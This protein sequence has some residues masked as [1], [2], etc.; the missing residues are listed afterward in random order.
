MQRRRLAPINIC[1]FCQAYEESVA[2]LLRECSFV[3]QLLRVFQIPSAPSSDSVSWLGWLA[4]FFVSLSE[5]NRRLLAMIY[6]VVWFA[7]NKLVHEG[8]KSSIH[9][10]SCFIKAFVSEQD[11]ICRV[12]DHASPTVVS[13]WETPPPS[14][15]KVN[16]DS[17]FRQQDRAATSGVVARDSEDLVLA[18]CVTPH[19]N[20]SDAFVAEALACK[21]AVQFAKDMGFL[22]VI[23]EGDSLTVVKKL[24]SASHDR[25]ANKV[26][27]SLAR[28]FYYVHDPCYWTELVPPETFAAAEADRRFLHFNQV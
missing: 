7:R 1:P 5:K 9:E 17:A 14:V 8:Y 26:A 22:N 15:V 6:W 11:T 10:T 2:H 21:V 13:R 25:G 18:A 27:H 19:S 24:N 20:I 28:E 3:C 16:F 12:E 23:I 4:A